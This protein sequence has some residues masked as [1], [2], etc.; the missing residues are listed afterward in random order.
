MSV[1]DVSELFN[2]PLGDG[3]MR[4]ALRAL[5]ADPAWSFVS[6]EDHDDRL[7]FGL[8]HRPSGTKVNV[9]QERSIVGMGH[10]RL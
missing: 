8:V 7:M 10:A 5:E 6:N 4:Q 9:A 2:H 3:E 1:H